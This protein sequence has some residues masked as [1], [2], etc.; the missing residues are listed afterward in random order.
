MDMFNFWTPA[1]P[2]SVTGEDER[3]HPKDKNSILDPTVDQ[4]QISQPIGYYLARAAASSYYNTQ[5][6]DALTKIQGD[7]FTWLTTISPRFIT[8]A[9]LKWTWYS[10]FFATIRA[11][12]RK[13]LQRTGV[14]AKGFDDDLVYMRNGAGVKLGTVF[15]HFKNQITDMHKQAE[16]RLH[17]SPW[18]KEKGASTGNDIL[19]N[20]LQAG[21]GNYDYTML[22]W[23][24]YIQR[25]N[26]LYLKNEMH[27][28][29]DSARNGNEDEWTGIRL[30]VFG[31]THTPTTTIGDSCVFINSGTWVGTQFQ[32]YVDIAV[33]RTSGATIHLTA[34]EKNFNELEQSSLVIDESNAVIVEPNNLTPK[35][36]RVDGYK[37]I[38]R[39]DGRKSHLWFKPHKKTL[40]YVTSKPHR[41]Q[42]ILTPPAR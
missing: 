23:S 4:N 2:L 41:V 15:R 12:F 10:Y 18:L 21:V 17:N 13:A 30:C 22:V 3:K 37:P 35:A 5:K 31:H 34:K 33:Q 6:K 39:L 28:N 1:K 8:L 40:S 27:R 36:N 32:T 25:A 38:Y 19:Y 20:M 11:L 26:Q 29:L 42:L 9:I 16:A 14:F 24:R 7:S